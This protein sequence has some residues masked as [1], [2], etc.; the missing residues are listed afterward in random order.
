M[1]EKTCIVDGVY[2]GCRFFTALTSNR[3][4]QRHYYKVWREFVERGCINEVMEYISDYYAL[5]KESYDNNAQRWGD[6]TDY[7][8]L[9]PQMQQWIKRR[10]DHIVGNLT[11]YA[12]PYDM[13]IIGYGAKTA[14]FLRLWQAEPLCPVDWEKFNAQK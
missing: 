3:E 13:P 5:V 4:F 6:D 7:A 14:N 8:A 11:V 9:V 12:V 10:H 2:P 1:T